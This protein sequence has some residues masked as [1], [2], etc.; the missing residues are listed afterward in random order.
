MSVPPELHAEFQ[1]HKPASHCSPFL[2]KYVPLFLFFTTKK[3]KTGLT[4]AVHAQY[5]FKRCIGSLNGEERAA[6]PTRSKICKVIRDAVAILAALRVLAGELVFTVAAILWHVSGFSCVGDC[7]CS[8][9]CP[10]SRGSR[11]L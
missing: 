8:K 1:H 2:K 10:F 6:M 5:D 4:T 7:S 11:S 3:W 9:S